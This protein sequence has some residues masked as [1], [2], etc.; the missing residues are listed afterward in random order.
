MR[1]PETMIFSHQFLLVTR[2]KR[3]YDSVIHQHLT[4][5][6]VLNT[7]SKLY[8]IDKKSV[9]FVKFIFEA[10]DGIAVVETIDRSRSM[11]KLHVAPGCEA[12]V[13]DLIRALKKDIVI[14]PVYLAP[15]DQTP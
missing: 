6:Y 3:C 5:G 11:I 9:G 14:E 15:E 7:T 1:V 4:Y 13:D 12:D 8:I 10:Y 2:I